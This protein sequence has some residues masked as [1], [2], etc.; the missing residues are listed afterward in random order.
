MCDDTAARPGLHNGPEMESRI[1]DFMMRFNPARLFLIFMPA[2]LA[3]LP[4]LAPA[5]PGIE[6]TSFIKHTILT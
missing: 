3:C 4:S 2:S 1:R 5:A 6:L